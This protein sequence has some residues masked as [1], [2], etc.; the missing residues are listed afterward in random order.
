MSEIVSYEVKVGHY[1]VLVIL[2]AGFLFCSY[3]L[4]LLI[5][6]R[7]SGLFNDALF[8]YLVSAMPNVV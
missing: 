3:L 8:N 1:I 6:G 5:D 2:L 7:V 4:D